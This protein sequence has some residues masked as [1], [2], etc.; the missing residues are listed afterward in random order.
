MMTSNVENQI[1]RWH[2]TLKWSR[3]LVNYAI[4]EA[5]VLIMKYTVKYF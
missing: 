1:L 3:T 4:A 5:I 2:S